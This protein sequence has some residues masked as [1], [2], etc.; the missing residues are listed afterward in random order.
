M[1]FYLSIY[2]YFQSYLIVVQGLSVSAAGR[3]VQTFTF[4]ST[5]TGIIVSFTIKRTKHYKYIVVL[6]TLVYVIGLA[7]MLR[8]R[9]EEASLM[10]IVATQTVVGVGGSMIHVPAQLGV[11]ASASHQEVAAATAIFLTILEIGGAVGNAISGAIWTSSIPVKLAEYLPAETRDQADAIFGN[12]TLAAT[13]WPMGS[14]TRVAINLAYQE[15]MT[16]ILTMAVCL[17]APC[18]V[19]SF[20]MKNYKLDE[21]DQHVKG[22]VVGRVQ[23][24]ADRHESEPLAGSSRRSSC[25]TDDETTPEVRRN[26]R[27]RDVFQKFRRKSS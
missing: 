13:G 2:P 18:I 16:K 4:T 19:L 1:A 14:P 6:G 11:Q 8:Y 15:T 26:S 10:L 17:A 5:V 22:V 12:V 3:I 24:V 7:L 25:S 21:M 27:V 9:T 20:F 23:E